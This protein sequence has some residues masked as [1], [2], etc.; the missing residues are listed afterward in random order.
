MSPV[1]CAL[2]LWLSL[3]GAVSVPDL[4]RYAEYEQAVISPDGTYLAITRRID[5]GQL[6]NVLR[7]ADMT[8]VAALSGGRDTE[9][10]RIVWAT[11]ERLLIEPM[12]RYGAEDFAWPSGEILGINA[13]GTR[14]AVLF[15]F[16]AG[17][18]QTGTHLP[19]R[20]SERASASIIDVLPDD[21]DHVLIEARPWSAQGQSTAAYRMDVFSG[22]LSHIASTPNTEGGLLSRDESRR[23]V[24]PRRARPARAA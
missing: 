18:G 14:R 8:P 16:R 13:D 20:E 2:S 7:V 10:G 23:A 17:E 4:A 5:S 15:G 19:Q 3:G 6:L 1:A 22:R 11:D 21:P 9:V 24:D 12:I